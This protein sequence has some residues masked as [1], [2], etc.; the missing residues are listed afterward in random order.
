MTNLQMTTL[1]FC[2][3]MMTLKFVEFQEDNYDNDEDKPELQSDS[4][5]EDNVKNESSLE[6]SILHQSH[7]HSDRVY[8]Q[9]LCQLAG[10]N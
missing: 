9:L 5:L 1:L 4:E 3:K 10:G 7:L 8:I 6:D 2:K